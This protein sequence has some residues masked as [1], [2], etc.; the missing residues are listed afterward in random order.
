MK[1]IKEEAE[2][3]LKMAA[4]KMKEQYDHSKRDAPKFKIGDIV[5]HNMKNLH[6]T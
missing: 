2:V 6:T 4:Q 3:S 5:L 1:S